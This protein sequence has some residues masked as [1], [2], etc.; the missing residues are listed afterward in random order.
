MPV[1]LATWE[2]AIRRIVVGGQPGQKICEAPI[3][4]NKKLG[5]VTHTCHPS[6]MGS[7]NMRIEVQDGQGINSRRCLKNN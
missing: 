5:M 4:A 2:M 3:S 6:Y 1:I 7:V